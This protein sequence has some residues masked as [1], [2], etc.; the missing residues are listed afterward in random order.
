MYAAESKAA[1][2]SESP[3]H[4][5]HRFVIAAVVLAVY[6]PLEPCDALTSLFDIS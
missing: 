1:A 6:S 5:C 3:A 2:M 4:L